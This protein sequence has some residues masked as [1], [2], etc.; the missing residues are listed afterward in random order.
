MKVVRPLLLAISLLLPTPAFAADLTLRYNQPAS[1][2]RNTSW[3]REALAIGNGRIGAMIF[4][5]LPR[6]R[7]QFNDITLWTGDENTAGT[8]QAFGNLY[9]NLPGHD[10]GFTDYQR[11]LS[12]DHGLASASYKKDGI[13]YTRK[14]IASHTAQCIIIQ[15]TADKPGAYT[16]EIELADMHNAKILADNNRITASGVLPNTLKYESQVLVKNQGG[17]LSVNGT[18]ISFTNA[19]SLTLI[20]N[21]GTSYVLDYSKKFLGADPHARITDQVNKAAEQSFDQLLGAHQKDYAALFNRVNLDL[22]SNPDRE[23]LP[24]NE[25]LAQYTKT[26]NDPGLEALFFQFGRYLMFSCSRDILPANLQGLWN[27][28]NRPA[29]NSD[30]HTNINIQMNYWLAEPANLSECHLPLFNMIDALLPALRLSTRGATDFESASAP[31]GD[32]K[33]PLPTDPPVLNLRGWTVRTSLNP[34]GNQ[35][36]KWNHPGN[37]WLCQHYWE[38]YA[39]TQDQD[40]LRTTAY[41]IMKEACQFW[42]DYL[43]PLPDGT[44]VAP[45]G[46]SPE[47]GPVSDGTIYDQELIWDLFTNT[48]DAADALATDKDFRDQLVQMREKLAKPKIGSWGQIM[49]WQTE[50]NLDN[51]NNNHRHASHLIGL[52]PGKQISPFTSPDLAKAAKVTLDARTDAGTGWSM[53]WKIAFHA[54]LLDGDRAHKMLRGILGTPGARAAQVVSRGNEGWNKGGVY[55]NLFDTHPPFQIDGNFGATAA[56]CEMLLQSQNGELHL[57]PA[58]PSEWKTGAIT[59]LRARGHYEVDLRWADGKLTAAT[60]HALTPT[61]APEIKI[62]SGTKTLTLPLAPGT[63]KTLDGDLK[64]VP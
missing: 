12:L 58:L 20:L 52:F 55:D 44:L 24:T 46:W 19:D 13:T 31:R 16:G 11:S 32:V 51:P 61:A 22:G 9:I 35:S 57:L 30:Y 37:A 42:Q 26:G 15:L 43:K 39:F 14:Y 29:W 36:W 62:R 54:R 17:Q 1:I 6:D 8:Y 28:N 38:H 5:D 10:A 34:F 21:A 7:I 63:A 40:F 23:K 60:I 27:D 45:K 59:G 53:A 48:I 47:Q 56:M 3:E 50:I 2:A 25:R 64:L 33:T 18:K 4:A 49:E 41:P